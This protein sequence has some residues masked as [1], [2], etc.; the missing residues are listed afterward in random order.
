MNNRGFA[1][2]EAPKEHK[3][4][5]PA[6]FSG[7]SGAYPFYPYPPYGYPYPYP[8]QQQGVAVPP[9]YYGAGVDPRQMP[10]IV[11]PVAFVPYVTQE[12]P[13]MQ[14]SPVI[15]EQK[16]PQPAQPAPQPAPSQKKR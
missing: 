12:Q 15:E 7:P 10:P 6:N 9:A 2:E 8:P 3:K 11:Q 5:E 16:K 4:D 1:K 14:Y 13:L